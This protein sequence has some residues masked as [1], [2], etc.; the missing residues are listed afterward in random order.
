M[1]DRPLKIGI[2]CYPSVGGSGILASELGEELAQR[3]HAIHFI[4][5][6]PP[7][8]MP[9][10]P[11][12]FF[13]PVQVSSYDLFKYPDYT[14]PLS[15]KMA[16]V[17]RVHRLDVLHVHYAVPHATAAILARAML[18]AEHR[19][20][21]I[22]TLH[23]TD[24]TL[25]GRDP[26]YGPAIRHA[27]EHSDAITTVSEFMRGETV[28]LLGVQRP[29]EV[30]HN[31][32]APHAPRRSRAEVRRELGVTDGEALLL[33]ISNL[34]PLKRLDLLLETVAKLPAAT[35]FKLVVL[36]GGDPAPLRAEATRL[37][38]A[39][40]LVVR[41][42][43]SDVEDYL[44][45]ADAGLFTSEM[46]SFCLS[47]LELMS[48]GCPSAAFAVGGIPEVTRSGETGLL[49]PLGDTA[50]LAQAVGTLI[51]DPARRAALGRAAQQR[52]REHF[53]A[54]AIV[55]RYEALYRR[56]CGI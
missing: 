1:S 34:R 4:S 8:R 42:R 41:E 26:G 37:G 3:G 5:Y 38:L 28:R 52:A 10:G 18:H 19:L 45:T 30:I 6:E 17:S 14:L 11:N 56:V 24:T 33:H 46:E 35:A 15:V 31:F 48:F 50:A 54:A 53:S 49:V 9:A 51:A 20:R 36:A 29:V 44:Q 7:F 22:T 16:E 40:R 12:V 2:T 27:L 13:H 25:L 39:G 23:G 21:I 47:I 32:F 55:P 43:V